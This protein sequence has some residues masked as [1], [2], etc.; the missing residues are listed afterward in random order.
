MPSSVIEVRPSLLG[1]MFYLRREFFLTGW[2]FLDIP[3]ATRFGSSRVPVL[4]LFH[5]P[6]IINVRCNRVPF[7]YV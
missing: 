4:P 6:I 1:G 3:C 7:T 2:R 5:Y